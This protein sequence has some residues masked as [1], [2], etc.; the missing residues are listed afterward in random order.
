[1]KTTQAQYVELLK[2]AD[3]AITGTDLAR[4]E[5][6]EIAKKVVKL[7]AAAQNLAAFLYPE[8][9]SKLYLRSAGDGY[10]F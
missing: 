3:E 1:M 5:N 10:K 2:M 8:P 7:K 4:I 6:T 9:K